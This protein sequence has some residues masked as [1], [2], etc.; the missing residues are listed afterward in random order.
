MPL[1]ELNGWRAYWQLEPWGCAADDH[2][3]EM[4]LRMNFAIHAKKGTK[5][6][7][8]FIDRDPE[9]VVKREAKPTRK[10]LEQ[11]IRQAL[12]RFK[13]TRVAPVPA[14]ESAPDK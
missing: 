6:P 14:K 9:V 11:N 12:A 1:D 13:V 10:Q 5:I 4:L 2:R 8:K 7:D 3:T